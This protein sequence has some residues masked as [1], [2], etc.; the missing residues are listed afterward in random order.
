MLKL[1]N[2]THLKNILLI[3]FTFGV[4]KLDKF[5]EDNKVQPLNIEVT[6]LTFDF[7]RLLII[8][9]DSTWQF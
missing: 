5:N 6:S 3:Y 4:K 9:E 8:N 7:P 1:L 2:D